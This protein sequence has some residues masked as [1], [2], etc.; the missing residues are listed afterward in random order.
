[1]IPISRYITNE[2]N[3]F[4]DTDALLSLVGN[5]LLTAAERKPLAKVAEELD[6]IWGQVEASDPVKW[7]AK[8]EELGQRVQTDPSLLDAFSTAVTK[9]RETVRLEH[10]HY[11][12]RYN[13]ASFALAPLAI[14]AT[15]RLIE[16]VN[17][18]LIK[19]RQFFEALKLELPGGDGGVCQMSEIEARSKNTLR[20]WEE[21]LVDLRNPAR[22]KAAIVLFDYGLLP[23]KSSSRQQGES[24][25]HDSA[26]LTAALA[27]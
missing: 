18:R 14:K 11:H 10:L 16:I 3:R 7:G 25:C 24:N 17:E 19:A 6:L 21:L 9:P 20:T 2:G 12:A 5:Q 22:S 4:L 23:I 27:A 15:K 26:H 13:S 1:M 8:V